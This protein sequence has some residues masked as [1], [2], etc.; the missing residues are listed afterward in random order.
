MLTGSCRKA[1]TFLI[2]L[3]ITDA[4]KVII[5]LDDNGVVLQ[6][7]IDISRAID[8]SLDREQDY[9]LEWLQQGFSSPLKKIR[10]YKKKYR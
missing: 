7:C 10:Q 1:I 5:T 3:A 6:D 9:S 8:A 4:F 2:D